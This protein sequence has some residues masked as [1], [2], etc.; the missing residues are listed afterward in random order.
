MELPQ[1][2][3][4]IDRY[5]HHV[6]GCQTQAELREATVPYT[7]YESKL[8]EIFAQYPDHPATKHDHL[9]PLFSTDRPTPTVRARSPAR[10]P[11]KVRD[12]YLLPLPDEERLKYGDPAIVSDIDEFKTNFK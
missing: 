7:R 4:A 5:L 12:Q 9:V 3:T 8:R 2:P 1:L 11:E 10:E 6:E